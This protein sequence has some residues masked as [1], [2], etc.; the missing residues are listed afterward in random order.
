M[1]EIL[2]NISNYSVTIVIVGL[3]LWD[4]FSNK[5]DMKDTLEVIKET[6]LNI[7]KSLDLLQKT[8]ERQDVKIDKLI[9][10]S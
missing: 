3:F 10:R 5:K 7:S 6:S 9:E 1:E 8:L 2:V 4:W